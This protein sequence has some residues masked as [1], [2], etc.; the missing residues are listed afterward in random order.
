MIIYKDQKAI[1]STSSLVR[2]CQ[3]VHVEL[4][5]RSPAAQKFIISPQN[6]SFGT[7]KQGNTASAISDREQLN[8]PDQ[9]SAT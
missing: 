4:V 1:V 3:S 7:L 6:L 8:T 5:Y 9:W 2:S